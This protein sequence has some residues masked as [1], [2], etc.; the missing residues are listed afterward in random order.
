MVTAAHA[1]W[2][3]D[4]ANF[5]LENKRMSANQMEAVMVKVFGMQ[6]SK[7]RTP[8]SFYPHNILGLAS[9][10]T[11][12]WSQNVVKH[13][14]RLLMRHLWFAG[15]HLVRRGCMRGSAELQ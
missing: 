9:E 8:L 3:E 2:L 4:S 13:L 10:T 6:P 15:V 1:D 11:H 14:I 12:A 7:M 5:L